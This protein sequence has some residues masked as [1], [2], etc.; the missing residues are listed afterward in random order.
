MSRKLSCLT[1]GLFVEVVLS[2]YFVLQKL[3]A[4]EPVSLRDMFV[5]FLFFFNDRICL[6]TDPIL[7][8]RK[9][10]GFIQKSRKAVVNLRG[11]GAG[12]DYGKA[13]SKGERRSSSPLGVLI[14]FRILTIKIERLRYTFNY[15][16]F[17][18]VQVSMS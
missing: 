18:F 7:E 14:S 1:W 11:G 15:L 13:P 10:T 12:A 17:C 4:G 6:T 8:Q 2:I 9:M 16:Y 5:M 3:T